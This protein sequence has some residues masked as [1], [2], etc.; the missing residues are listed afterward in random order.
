MIYLIPPLARLKDRGYCLYLPE[1]GV[2][3]R[4][5]NSDSGI[6][7]LLTTPF[8][9]PSR[10]PIIIQHAQHGFHQ[11][12]A[13][14]KQSSPCFFTSQRARKTGEEKSTWSSNRASP[15]DLLLSSITIPSHSSPQFQRAL[16]VTQLCAQIKGTVF[17]SN[18]SKKG[19]SILQDWPIYSENE[20]SPPAAE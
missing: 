17:P 12:V 8:S 4:P 7:I 18:A 13:N 5:P 2:Q 3:K 19:K 6:L 16:S 11:T 14:Y 10:P 1:K 9:L 15:R 20:R